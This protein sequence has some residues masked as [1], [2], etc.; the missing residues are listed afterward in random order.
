MG[1]TKKVVDYTDGVAY[2]KAQF[3]EFYGEKKANKIWEAAKRAEEAPTAKAK[4]KEKKPKSVNK[5][6]NMSTSVTLSNGVEMPLFG[7]G[8]AFGNW[9]DDSQPK[10]FTPEDAWASTKMA[11]D[12]GMRHLDCAFVY[13]THTHVRDVCGSYFMSG[14]LKRSDVFI[15]TK[16]FHPPVPGFLAP[17]KVLDMDNPATD[18]KAQ[19]EQHLY[20]CLEELGVGSVDLLLAHWPGPHGSKDAAQNRRNRKLCWEALEKFHKEGKAKS[21]GVSNWN[22]QHLEDLKSD[23]ITVVPHVNQIEM[24]PY[25]IWTKLV[26]YCKANNITVQAYSPLGSS[27][28]GP[29]KDPVVVELAEKYKKNPGQLVLRWLVQQGIVVLP[30]SSSQA[31]IQSNMDVFDFEISAE[32]MEK[33]TALNKGKTFTNESPYNIA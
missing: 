21:I 26:E 22:E 1:K 19:L 31:R 17:S 30:R 24:S 18:I 14:K 16:I 28:G 13:G 4:A 15:T 2:T 7:F 9:S 32:D 5:K 8:E 20:A 25:T 10:G 12:A 27:G 11:L 6:P 3:T 33:I 23:G 29:L